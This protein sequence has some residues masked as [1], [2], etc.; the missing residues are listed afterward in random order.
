MRAYYNKMIANADHIVTTAFHRPLLTISTSTATGLSR[1]GICTM[2]TSSRMAQ[3][4]AS[5]SAEL[6]P[7][8]HNAAATRGKSPAS[9]HRVDPNAF[10]NP[11][12]SMAEKKT[13]GWAGTAGG[14]VGLILGGLATMVLKKRKK[15]IGG[16]I[17]RMSAGRVDSRDV[18]DLCETGRACC[19]GSGPSRSGDMR[20]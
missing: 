18:L 13:A 5:T 9:M 2:N 1:G 11:I 10:D 19:T 12:L 16:R 14:A 20:R 8:H 15:D 7:P 17:A 3:V 6:S 4:F